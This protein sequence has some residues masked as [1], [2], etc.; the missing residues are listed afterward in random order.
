V[1]ASTGRVGIWAPVAIYMALIFAG[2]SLSRPPQ[3]GPDVSDKLLHFVVYAGLG[4]VL[5]RALS[6]R[7]T[8]P[9]TAR[10]AVRAALIAA[11]YG[12]SDELHQAFVPERDSEVLDVAADAAGAAIA[13]GALWAWDIIRGRNGL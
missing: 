7:W 10:V 13:S 12:A 2:S 5:V 11:V 9:V 4:V 3:V 8:A 6:R 1:R